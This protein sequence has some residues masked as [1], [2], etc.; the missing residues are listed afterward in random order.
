MSRSW[1]LGR[2]NATSA[3]SPAYRSQIPPTPASSATMPRI[4]LARTWHARGG[5][6]VADQVEE[7]SEE[8]LSTVLVGQEGKPD[9]NDDEAEDAA[10]G[11]QQTT[12]A[13]SIF[14]T[15]ADYRHEP[16]PAVDAP[17]R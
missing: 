7:R 9:G 17:R 8:A 3:E 4:S 13:G 2:N 16:L 12:K 14:G 6:G 11:Q 5:C 10:D 15:A 1:V